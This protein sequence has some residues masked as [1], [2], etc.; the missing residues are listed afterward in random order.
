MCVTMCIVPIPRPCLQDIKSVLFGTNSLDA[1]YQQCSGGQ[2]RLD[3]S[4]SVVFPVSIP[5][6][7]TNDGGTTFDTKSCK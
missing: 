1:L 5:C 2:A 4:N 6:S 7:G 3:P